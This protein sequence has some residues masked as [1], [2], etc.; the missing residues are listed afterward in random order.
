MLQGVSGSGFEN[1]KLID[2]FEQAIKLTHFC[3]LE[4]MLGISGQEFVQAHLS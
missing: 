1:R 3:G 4:L 2:S